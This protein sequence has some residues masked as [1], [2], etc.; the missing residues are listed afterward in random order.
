MEL[1][2]CVCGFFFF[3]HFYH[4]KGSEMARKFYKAL[5]WKDRVTPKLGSFVFYST[6]SKRR[7]QIQMVC[8][9]EH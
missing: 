1:N 9:S 3:S 6:K 7:N 4:S 8:V 2:V 5:V